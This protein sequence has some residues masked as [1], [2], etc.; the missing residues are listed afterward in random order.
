MSRGILSASFG[1]RGRP[2]SE[3]STTATIKQ[4][5]TENEREPCRVC[6]IRPRD[7]FS[8]LCQVCGRRNYHYGT[9][10]PKFKPFHM[11]HILEELTVVKTIVTRNIKSEAVTLGLKFFE[12]LMADAALLPTVYG[13]SEAYTKFIRRWAEAGVQ[14]LDL[15]VCCGGSFLNYYL[16]KGMI[17]SDRNLNYVMGNFAV[18][19][20]TGVPG[21]IQG[22]AKRAIS[23]LIVTHI[24]P[25]LVNLAKMGV[26]YIKARDAAH[27]KMA[28]SLEMPFIMEDAYET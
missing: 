16:D 3:Q 18:R 6:G 15:L 5:Q 21:S 9:T 8:P 7:N 25:L 27:L 28:A 2:K 4:K 22:G 23:G 17:V 14:P 20:V 19:M 11:K 10:D 13:L 24:G 26:E 1:K 12:N